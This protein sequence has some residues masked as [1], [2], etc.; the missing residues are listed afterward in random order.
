MQLSALLFWTGIIGRVC[1][2]II[3]KEYFFCNRR[4]FL[5]INRHQNRKAIKKWIEI[6]LLA[7]LKWDFA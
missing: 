1:Y 7:F 4:F 6:L 5:R 3:S 2:L